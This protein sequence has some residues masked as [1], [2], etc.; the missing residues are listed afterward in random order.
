MV[1]NKEKNSGNIEILVE[2]LVEKDGKKITH[3]VE[4][5]NS[6]VKGFIRHLTAYLVTDDYVDAFIDTSGSANWVSAGTNFTQTALAPSGDDNYGILVGT[7]SQTVN[8]DQYNLVAKILHGTTSG[9]LSYGETIYSVSDTSLTMTITITR[10]FDNL[11]GGDI[12][13]NEVG[14]FVKYTVGTDTKYAM[15]ARDVITATTI[16]NGGRLTV[17][18]IIQVNP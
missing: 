14:L 15:I 9:R 2:T 11:S 6:F 3:R 12:T 18:Y 13:V 16:P 17:R 4:K 7:S 10:M 5:A 8:Q 1:S